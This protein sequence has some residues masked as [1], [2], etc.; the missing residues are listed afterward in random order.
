MTVQ[1][2][3]GMQSSWQHP[4]SDQGSGQWPYLEHHRCFLQN[5][6]Q[7]HD[8]GRPMSRTKLLA[9]KNCLEHVAITGCR[10]TQTVQYVTTRKDVQTSVTHSCKFVYLLLA[11]T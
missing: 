8:M 1:P 3:C 6:S 5:G 4:G 2:G 11:V 10:H 7:C 9:G